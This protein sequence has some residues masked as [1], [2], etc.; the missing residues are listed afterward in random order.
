MDQAPLYH[1]K[2]SLIALMA[3][4]ASCPFVQAGDYGA[5]GASSAAGTSAAGYY[6]GGQ[7]DIARRAQARREERT[8]ESMNTLEKGRQYYR[9]QKYKEALDEYNR[10][11]DLL[12]KAPVTDSRRAFIVTSIGDASVAL[13]QQYV[14]IGQYD[15]ARQLL[16]DAIKINPF[17]KLAQR[18]LAY[19]DDP[20]RTNPAKTPQYVKDV[21]EVNTLLRMAYG[22]FDLG[23]FDAAKGKFQQVLRIDPYNTAARRGMETVDRRRDQY[24]RAAYDQTRAEM[25]A[26]VTKAWETPLPMEIPTGG[27]VGGGQTETLQGATANTMKLKSLIIPVVDFEDTTVEEAIEFLRN[28]SQQLDTS[29][30]PNGERGINFVISDAQAGGTPSP[31]ADTSL[32]VS[33][34]EG[35]DG[36]DAAAPVA[37]PAP[38][39]KTKRIKQLKLRNVPMIEVLKFICQNAGLRYKVEDYAVAILPSGGSETDFFTRTFTVPPNFISSLDSASGE[40]GDSAGADPFADASSSGGSSAI[41][42]RPPVT[43]L[44][45]NA[46]VSFPDGA[47]ASYF[48]G[49]STLLVRNS[50]ANL[51]MVEQLIENLKGKNKQVKIMTKFVE[52]TQENTDELSFDWVV[53][54]FSV[55]DSRSVFMGGGNGNGSNL[56][57]SDFVSAPSSN[58]GNWPINSTNNLNGLATGGIRSGSG[59]ISKDGIDNLLRSQNRTQATA[60]SPAPGI[61]SMTGIYDEGSFQAIMRGLN[62]KKGSDVLT[63]PSVT[64]KPGDEATIQIIR[65]FIYPTAFEPPQIPQSTGS[66]YNDSYRGTSS[67]LD[68]L[69][70]SSQP[71]VNSFPVTPTT[72]T[73]FEMKPVGVTLKVAPNVG[74]NDYVIDMGFEPSIIEFEGFVNYG[75]P[76]QSTGVGSDGQPVSIT[77]TDNRIEQPIFST[78]SVK[79]SLFIYDGHTVAI[80][81]LIS[82]SVQM[83]EDKVP[84]FGDLPFVGRFFRGNA[85]SHI[86]KNLMIFVT[87][88]IIDATGQPI[89][90]RG[91]SEA[92]NGGD[93][94]MVGGADAGLLPPVP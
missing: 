55:N 81:G 54:P 60:V 88:Q 20:A 39:V 74:E 34:E 27:E 38:D 64:A 31:V 87:G 42:P 8:Q 67:L 4:A 85:E 45:K 3:I 17:N 36:A 1:S 46:G 23:Q 65:E 30:G 77:L 56:S 11:L 59:A 37:A 89:R 2:R 47:S 33:F 40:S 28:R 49:N 12:P 50:T 80:G 57:S 82:E 91:A 93:T 32:D 25:L 19:L 18:E 62:Q 22:F 5:V 9:D 15:E 48:A 94:A 7:A 53:T 86:K 61:L 6:S 35:V 43:T 75:S 52:I 69:T 90:G 73:E 13:A 58:V 92:P 79:T 26:E 84:I 70:G 24:Y 41:R 16:N 29:T 72:P 71:T 21:E 66:N 10:A 78:R 63:A 68:G 51:D 44:L 76:I 83:V 14:K